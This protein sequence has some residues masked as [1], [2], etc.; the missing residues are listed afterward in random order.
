MKRIHSPLRLLPLLLLAACGP[1]IA[2]DRTT[3]PGLALDA[4]AASGL[5][6]QD[7]LPTAER[8]DPPDGPAPLAATNA[9][10]RSAPGAER[11]GV[12]GPDAGRLTAVLYSEQDVEVRARIGGVLDAVHAELGDRLAAGA[13]LA[14]LDA[15]EQ[16]AHHAA[17]EAATELARS[18]HARSSELAA[19]EMI[20]RAELEDMVYRLRASEAGLRDAAV[21]LSWTQVRAPFAGVVARRFV[22]P[23]QWVEEG[24]PLFRITALA[25]LRALV[26]VPEGGARGIA[27][28][29]RARLVGLDGAEVAGRVARVAPAVDPVSGTIEVLVDVPDPGRLRPG[30]SVT[31]HFLPVR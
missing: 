20:T 5:A 15:R 14:E 2:T 17:A 24:Q 6:G 7:P 27:P 23:G 21:R 12:E 4:T 31:V 29:A 16:A 3:P 9:V 22:R 19:K 13:L 26:R 28:G 25:P 11:V 8:R 30:A 18:R 1:D 10:A